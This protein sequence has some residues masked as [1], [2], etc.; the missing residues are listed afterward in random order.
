MVNDRQVPTA[1]ETR[2]RIKRHAG[3][4]AAAGSVVLLPLTLLP[5][6]GWQ[7]PFELLS[8]FQVQYFFAALACVAVL[9][10]LRRWLWCAVS[11]ASLVLAG[12]S[13]G[14]YQ[15]A[16]QAAH[17]DVNDTGQSVRVLLANVL[18][19]NLQHDRVLELVRTADADVLVFQ[20]VNER[21]K[22]A[23]ERITDAYPYVAGKTREDPFGIMVYSRLPILDHGRL[24][25]DAAG[26][27]SLRLVID[28]R[29]TA[30]SFVCT[31]PR[32]PLLKGAFTHRNDQ[33]GRVTELIETLPR[34]L[35]LVGDLNTTMWSP[36]F[37]RLCDRGDLSSVR[38]GV[39]VLG[40]WPAALPG[41]MRIPIDHVLVSP[42]I[43]VGACRLG[44]PV[45]SDHLPL[46]VDLQMP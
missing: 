14:P 40:S 43:T 22:S 16:G 25:H 45:G 19:S 36:W 23:L 1:R 41:F 8:H 26:R 17:A 37:R 33:I 27:T 31:H 44:E 11:V 2:H 24:P 3:R 28:V 32:P 39:G 30:V 18:L 10:L 46:I 5:F 38:E 9:A 42:D 6:V 21:W 7:Y 4:L 29:G 13:V 15:G 12:V 20:E 34:P 35:V